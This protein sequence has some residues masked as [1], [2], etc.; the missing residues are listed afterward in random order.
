MHT[1][2]THSVLEVSWE[3][4]MGEELMK[5]SGFVSGSKSNEEEEE[6]VEKAMRQMCRLRLGL[7]RMMQIHSSPSDQNMHSS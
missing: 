6:E 7:G 4:L 1:A 2:V 3:A 5:N